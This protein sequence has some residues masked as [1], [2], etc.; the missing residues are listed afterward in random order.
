MGLT[1]EECHYLLEHCSTSVYERC[2]SFNRFVNMVQE[3]SERRSNILPLPSARPATVL[4]HQGLRQ[5]LITAAEHMIEAQGLGE[6]RARD[7]AKSAGCSLGAIY[8]VFA[9]LD[10]L[11]LEVNANT[12]RAIDQTMSAIEEPDPVLQ[13]LGLADAY[14]SYAAGNRL[15][16]DALFNHRMAAEATAPSWF[17]ELQSSAF[18]HIEGPLTVLCPGLVPEAR[19]LLGRNI[20]AAVHGMVALGLDKRVAPTDLPGLRVQIALVVRAIAQGLPSVPQGAL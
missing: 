14:T 10:E 3:K 4:R 17:L 11:I 12:L 6:L 20:F 15:R 9:D 16:W 2:S 1:A 7:L 5:E 13:F 19:A 18:S 8:N